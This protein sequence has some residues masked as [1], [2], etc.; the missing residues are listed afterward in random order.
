MQINVNINKDEMIEVLTQ[1]V[2]GALSSNSRDAYEVFSDAIRDGVAKAI[3]E[4]L[5]KDWG[6]DLMNEIA[7]RV[8][9]RVSKVNGLPVTLR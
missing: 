7:E 3:S 2:A 8:A 1:T 6:Y 4:K 9:E 5:S